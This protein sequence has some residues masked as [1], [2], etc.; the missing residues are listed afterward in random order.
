LYE[1]RKRKHD[2]NMNIKLPPMLGG[3]SW[4]GSS[5]KTPDIM[6][7]HNSNDQKSMQYAILFLYLY[8]QSNLSG[9][10]DESSFE[11]H[12]NARVKH[13]VNTQ[14]VNKMSGD[15]VKSSKSQLMQGYN[16]RK[17]SLPIF[18]TSEKPTRKSKLLFNFSNNWNK[19]SSPNNAANMKPLSGI[20]GNRY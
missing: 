16:D 4:G 19:P 17:S 18:K 9:C 10:I 1:N 6:P 7:Y 2:K 5:I 15:A 11:V 3:L 12:N 8:T 20:V 14:G 13:R